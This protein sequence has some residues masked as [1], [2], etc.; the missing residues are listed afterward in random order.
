M[1]R[2]YSSSPDSEILVESQN[3]DLK[4]FLS[5]KYSFEAGFVPDGYDTAFLLIREDPEDAFNDHWKIVLFKEVIGF[6]ND[7]KNITLDNLNDIETSSGK[8]YEDY[9]VIEGSFEKVIEVSTELI[10][11][12]NGTI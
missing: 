2:I 5:S 11:R 9:K 4:N 3:E 6:G 12:H 8:V 1:S 10:S 7:I